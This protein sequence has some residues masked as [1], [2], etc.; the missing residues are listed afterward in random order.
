ML[1]GQ[2]S[3]LSSEVER[4]FD[5]ARGRARRE[6]ADQLNQSVRR[7]RQS[8]SHDELAATLLD[9]ATAFASG[10]AIFRIAEGVAHGEKVRGIAA[11]DTE[12]FSSLE[13]PLTAAP[14][15]AGAVESR[16]PVI[17]VTT[18]AEVSAR[19]I[20]LASHQPDGRTYIY[21]LV[22]KDRVPMLLYCWGTVHGPVHGPV[23]GPV[24]EMLAQVAAAVWDSLVVPPPPEPAPPQSALQPE[25]VTIAPAPASTPAP[26]TSWDALPPEDQ[27]IHLR[28]QRFARVQVAEMRLNDAAAVQSGRGQRDLYGAL[29]ARID[30]ARV[31]FRQKF[32]APGSSMVD[33][34]HVELVRT[35]AHDDADL[36]GKDY[37]GPLV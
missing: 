27:A 28:A 17:A 32:F 11:E 4:L 20:S 3:Q 31:T 8:E 35:L 9:S 7:I 19:L 15:L 22:V 24:L 18:A 2:L 10:A 21:P 37:P 33:Y 13:I 36:L 1:E 6:L 14:A 29:R 12:S 30:T 23:Q 5:E 16:D 26:A 25:L 34:I